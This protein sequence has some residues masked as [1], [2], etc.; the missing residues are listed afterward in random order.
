M[1]KPIKDQF[2]VAIDGPFEG[3]EG[4]AINVTPEE[5][6]ILW[7]T[8]LIFPLSKSLGHYEL[9]RPLDEQT[10]KELR[11]VFKSINSETRFVVTRKSAYVIPEHLP[12]AV[13]VPKEAHALD[14]LTPHQRR[15]RGGKSIKVA[16]SSMFNVCV[17]WDN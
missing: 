7:D 9:F 10:K 2:L 13:G 14:L 17:V 3:Q 11:D 6:M 12:V 1:E 8:G 16:Y 15:V 5:I 4:K